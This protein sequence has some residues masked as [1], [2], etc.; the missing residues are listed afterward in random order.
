MIIINARVSIPEEEIT[1]TASRS[2]GPGGQHV[3]KTATKVTL[4]FDLGSTPSLTDSQKRRVREALGRMVSR[5][6]AIVLHEESHRSQSANRKRVIE[7]FSTLLA[8]A[9]APRKKRIPTAV[10]P[11]QKR[12]RLEEKRL[13]SMKKSSRRSDPL[14]E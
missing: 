2:S 13:R 5:S 14:Q 11:A 10:S 8:R 7:K 9:L 12:K 6:D 3:N 4:R 1:I